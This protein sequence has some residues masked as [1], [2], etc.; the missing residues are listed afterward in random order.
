MAEHKTYW[1]P[2][3]L[4]Q[5]RVAARTLSP[6]QLGSL[7][8]KPTHEIEQAL[9]YDI[10]RRKLKATTRT[11]VINGKTVRI[12]TISAGYAIGVLDA[13]ASYSS[14]SLF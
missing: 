4:V 6:D 3:R 10:N 1:T 9:R 8:D 5:L 7:F 14:H 11:E 12:T 13:R 2:K